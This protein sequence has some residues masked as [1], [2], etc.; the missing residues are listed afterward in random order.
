[1]SGRTRINSNAITRRC[2]S[3]SVLFLS[4]FSVMIVIIDYCIGTS[5]K[6]CFLLSKTRILSEK[7]LRVLLVFSSSN[8]NIFFIAFSLILPALKYLH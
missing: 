3:I 8:D 5:K 7:G 4:F 2:Y 1:V 6:A